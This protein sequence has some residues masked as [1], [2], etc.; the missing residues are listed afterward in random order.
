MSPHGQFL[1]EEARAYMGRLI[2]K[3]APPAEAAQKAGD[4]FGFHPSTVAT[5]SAQ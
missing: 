4:W 5:G 1:L 2:A 3:G